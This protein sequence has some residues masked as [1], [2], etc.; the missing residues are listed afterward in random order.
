VLGDFT[1]SKELLASLP[2]DFTFAQIEHA[3][4]ALFSGDDVEALLLAQSIGNA[5]ATKR[6]QLHRCLIATVAA[7]G[8]E[9]QDEAFISIGN[10]ARLLQ[11]HGTPSLLWSVPFEPLREAALAAREAGVCDIVD[12]VDAIP[13]PARCRRYERLT[14]M[15][16]R[17]LE[18][19]A[20]HRS[21][22]Q[23]ATALFITPGTVKKHL[24]AV[25]RKLQAKGR[26]EAILQAARMGLLSGRAPVT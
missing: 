11:S 17:T 1:A 25:Y 16:L 14:E 21:A 5:G 15:E 10:A 6:Q 4:L 22:G 3:R 8:C 24:A 20:E 13:E 9:R 18:A 19:I 2:D 26:D 7:W 23:A 12:T